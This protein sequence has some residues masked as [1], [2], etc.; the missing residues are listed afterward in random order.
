MIHAEEKIL[1]TIYDT[2]PEAI[3]VID[4]KGNVQ[5]FNRMAEHILGIPP[6]KCA[7]RT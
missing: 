6:M 7:G 2:S 3:I 1:Q 4:E 5:S